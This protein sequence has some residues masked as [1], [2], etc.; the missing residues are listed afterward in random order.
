MNDRQDGVPT[1]LGSR[2]PLVSLIQTLAAAGRLNFRHAAT[3]LGV[4][5]SSVSTR[6]KILEA[7]PS[8]VD[9]ADSQIS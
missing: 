8:R 7:D 1:T 3:A 5:V 4:S 6:V 2:I 9:K